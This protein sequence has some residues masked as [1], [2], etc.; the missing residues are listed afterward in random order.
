MLLSGAT[1]AVVADELDGG[2]ALRDLGEHQLKDF[3]E[4]ERIFE[5]RYPGAP[6][7]S[8]PLKS[9]AA[10]PADVP[11]A[12][13]FAR[14]RPRRRVVV[15]LAVVAV[16]L[17]AAAIVL[18]LADEDGLDRVA[19]NTV[20]VLSA[21]GLALEAAIP[22]GAAPAG[23]AVG[24]GSI[25]VSNTDE[26]TVSRIDRE[27]QEVVQVIPVGNGPAGIA[28]SGGFVWVAN[29]LDGTVSRIDPRV[30]GGRELEKIDV[31]N[32]P[33]GVAA[34]YGSVWVANVAD[35]T[36]SRI[37]PETGKAAGPIGAGAGVDVLAVGPTGVWVASRATDTVTQLDA[38]SGSELQRFNVGRGPSAMAVTAD[39]A[40]VATEFDGTLARLDP[41]GGGIRSTPVGSSPR[42]VAADGRTVRVTDGAGRLTEVDA[43]SGDVERR[44]RLGGR[45]G[46]LAATGGAVYVTVRDS[47]A[48]HV[49]G[50]LEIVGYADAVDSMDPGLAYSS[51]SV[52]LASVV[53]DGLVGFR[54]VGGTA[55]SDIVP[56][57]A[58]R[59][60]TIGDGGRTLTFRM[61]RGVRY[62]NG[63]PVRAGDIR[64]GI[65]RSLDIPESPGPA[66][67]DTIVGARHARATIARATSPRVW[68]PTTSRGPW[69]SASPGR[70]RTSC[71][72]SRS[73]PPSPCRR[74]CRG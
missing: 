71:T 23:I 53:G 59:M 52:P 55:G 69:S 65:E 57:L 72:S 38:R 74:R 28:V 63:E 43:R 42:G 34:G 45:P 68:P 48:R 19:S 15:G 8:P 56:D 40:W 9:L 11:F 54:R 37:D 18:A 16:A 17:S 13:R 30:A 21:D 12:R 70:T 47:G 73:R 61:R 51:L 3:A 10:Q 36:L 25:W 24:E 29:S 32:Q 39:A 4:P 22:V 62:S 5:V 64:R 58:V 2:L 14:A 66:F 50:T 44:A 60:P 67:N 33:T 26:G 1:R 31:G 6:E 20:A 49:G 27:R 41:D 46:A 7:A 35:K